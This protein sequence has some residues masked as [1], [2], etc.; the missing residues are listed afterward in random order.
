MSNRLK[1]K[2]FFTIQNNAKNNIYESRVRKAQKD[3]A[4][5]TFQRIDALFH[6]KKSR[7]LGDLKENGYYQASRQKV[8]FI[9]RQIRQ[10]THN[11]KY[12][13][14][15]DEPTGDKVVIGSTV[16]YLDNEKE[17]TYMIVGD[18][19]ANSLD[20]KISINSPLGTALSG[21]RVGDTIRYH[22]P[23]GERSVAILKVS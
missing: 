16:V 4:D 20:G 14:I 10:L 3:L 2:Y 23:R 22:T 15:S 1:T 13:V 9:D 18:T 12:A 21:H 7:E 11:I 8:N 19:E 17:Y 5:F 6:L